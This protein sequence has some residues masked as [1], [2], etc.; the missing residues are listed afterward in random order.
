[1]EKGSFL[2]EIAVVDDDTDVLE[3]V[4][5]SLSEVGGYAVDMYTSGADFLAALP[6]ISPQL[7]LLD[8]MMPG[9]DGLEV[10]RRLRKMEDYS[11]IPVVFLTAKVQPHEVETYKSYGAKDVI[12]KPFDAM[13]LSE[14]IMEIWHRK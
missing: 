13:T 9:M 6:T 10:L 7:I 12:I 4:K 3:I 1:M 8:V 14:T 5:F 2:H 11:S